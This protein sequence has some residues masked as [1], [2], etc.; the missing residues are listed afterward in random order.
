MLM[1]F[2]QRCFRKTILVSRDEY[3]KI[4]DLFK[5]PSCQHFWITCSCLRRELQ[6]FATTLTSCM[7]IKS[8][9][10][11][12]TWDFS[13]ICFKYA[14]R[15]PADI[16]LFK[17]NDGNTRRICR[18]CLKLTMKKQERCDESRCV[19]FEQ[20]SYTVIVFPLLNLNKQMVVG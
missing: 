1:T 7:F 9:K 5:I 15:I 19:N 2:F 12:R 17:V 11:I 14:R 13:C 18:T 8:I 3:F 10:D 6:L 20:I 4:L 16:Q